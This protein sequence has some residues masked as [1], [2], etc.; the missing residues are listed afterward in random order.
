M[1]FTGLSAVLILAVVQKQ[2]IAANDV[3]L[4]LGY[5][6]GL[7]NRPVSLLKSRW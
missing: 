5:R 1:S 4:A 7:W 6:S 3:E 2:S